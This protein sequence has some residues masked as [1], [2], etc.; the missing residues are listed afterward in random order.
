MMPSDHQRFPTP[1]QQL[2]LVR[3]KF[4]CASCG[5]HI[6]AVG[7]A[8]TGVHRFGERAEG[9]HVIPHKMGGPITVEN[10]VVVCRA[11]HSSAHQGG[12]WRDI[13]IYA[14]TANLSMPQKIAKI[15]AGYPH[16]RG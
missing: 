4:R 7:E 15:A 5:T 14:D 11:C 9:H 8:G 2:A 16:Y 10:C 6:S 12:R 3:Q 1:V 13:S